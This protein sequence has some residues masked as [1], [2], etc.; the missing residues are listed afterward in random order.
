MNY[1]FPPLRKIGIGPAPHRTRRI[2]SEKRTILYRDPSD[3]N[4]IF[5]TVSDRDLNS[6]TLSTAT[7]FELQ[8]LCL[9]WQGS[10]WKT[11]YPARGFEV[12][13]IFT[14]FKSTNE[15]RPLSIILNYA[16]VSWC[17]SLQIA[18]HYAR[19]ARILV[20]INHHWYRCYTVR[21]AWNLVEIWR[22][23]L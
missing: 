16:L 11:F 14:L 8:I 6:K 1:Y 3:S 2:R 4:L 23:I 10:T 20:T 9:N 21:Q 17:C 22:K 7:A 19:R 5:Y 12:S 13:P 15:K 18:E